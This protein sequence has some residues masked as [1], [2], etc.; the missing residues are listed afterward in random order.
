MIGIAKWEEENSFCLSLSGSTINS[1]YFTNSTNF[2]TLG[3]WYMVV[4]YIVANGTTTAPADSGVY[5]MVT[6]QK[7]HNVTNYQWKPNVTYCTNSG[8]LIR[9]TGID[10]TKTGTAYLY[11]VRLDEV[12]GTEPSLNEL[13]NLDT[14]TKSKASH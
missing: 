5:D 11:D 3:R 6:K 2:G 1:A 7:V 10:S 4:G 9:Y 12:N 13:L 14:T 8:C